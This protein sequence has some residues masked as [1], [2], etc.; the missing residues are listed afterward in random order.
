MKVFG[1][2]L[3]ILEPAR[4]PPRTRPNSQKWLK[5]DFQGLPKVPQKQPQSDVLTRKVTQKSLWGLLSSHFGGDP[6][7]HFLE[8]LWNVRGSGGS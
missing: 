4:I 5:S 6:E 2:S 7:S 1:L 8:L 3:K